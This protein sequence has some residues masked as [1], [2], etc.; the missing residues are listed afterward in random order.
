MQSA[1]CARKLPGRPGLFQ[2]FLQACASTE[3]FLK[4]VGL[5]SFVAELGQFC[6]FLEA[7]NAQTRKECF[8]IFVDHLGDVGKEGDG[9]IAE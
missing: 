4:F 6:A 5:G 2:N 3:L 7:V 9:T 1:C 8:E